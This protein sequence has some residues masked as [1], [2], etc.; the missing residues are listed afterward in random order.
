MFF[1]QL[2]MKCVSNKSKN[3]LYLFS[4]IK[5]VI[6]KKLKVNHETEKYDFEYRV[7]SVIIFIRPL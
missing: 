5:D 3:L 2:T 6:S 7:F 4:M 1:V